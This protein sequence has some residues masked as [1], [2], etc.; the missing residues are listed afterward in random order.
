MNTR[1]NRSVAGFASVIAI[2]AAAGTANAARHYC[3]GFEN[4]LM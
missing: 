4:V 1:L 2:S 3:F